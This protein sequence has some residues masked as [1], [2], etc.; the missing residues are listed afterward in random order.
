MGN[1]CRL[2]LVSLLCLSLNACILAATHVAGTAM[3]S[4]ETG[5]DFAVWKAQM[6]AIPPGT[7]RL[8]VYPGGSLSLVYEAT[9]IGTGGDEHFVVDRDVCKILGNSFVFLDLTAGKHVISADHVSKLLDGYEVGRY[10][11]D[12]NIAPST[13]TYVKIDK[14]KSG[15]AF[16]H[17]YVPKLVDAA[18][19]ESALRSSPIY[20]DGLKCKVNEAKDRAP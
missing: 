13:I 12:V 19:A 18:A 3:R 9:S 5:A 15:E 16:S 4:F 8:I 10:K 7:G 17:H 2:M 1:Y 11:L 6:P 14:E 20:S